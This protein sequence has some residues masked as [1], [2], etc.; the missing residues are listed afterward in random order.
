MA[1]LP[2]NSAVIIDWPMI[3]PSIVIGDPS[4]NVTINLTSPVISELAKTIA[5]G[6]VVG[7][8]ANASDEDAAELALS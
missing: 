4:G 5:R 6:D 1:S 8:Y 3:K 2:N 7:I